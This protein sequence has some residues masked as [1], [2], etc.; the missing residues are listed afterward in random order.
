MKRLLILTVCLTMMLA[1]GA[2][3]LVVVLSDGTM[4]YYLLGNEPKPV[5]TWENGVVSINTDKFS[6][7][8]VEKFYISDTDAPAAIDE[9]ESKPL[10]YDG[11]TLYVNTADK[12]VA[13]YTADGKPVEVK[14]TKTDRLTAV[15][16]GELRAGI[17]IIKVGKTSF[18]FYKK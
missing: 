11:S 6:V 7:S 17:Y 9:A 16:T 1:A 2:K 14:M 4:V 18:K 3:S 10:K 8:D 12:F 13:V 5:M 15:P